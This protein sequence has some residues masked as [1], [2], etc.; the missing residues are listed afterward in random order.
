MRAVPALPLAFV[1]AALACGGPPSPASLDARRDRCAQC[2]MVV[3]APS[4]AAQLVGGGAAPRFFDD[5]GC[6]R[7]WLRAHPEQP[8]GAVAFVADHRTGSWVRAGAATYARVPG[9]ATPMGSG[10]VAHQDAAS[11]LQDRSLGRALPVS[12]AELFGASGPPDVPR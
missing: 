4:F 5:L 2:G 6:L 1:L 10:L 7:E 12:V 9:L 3:A 8:R 11:R